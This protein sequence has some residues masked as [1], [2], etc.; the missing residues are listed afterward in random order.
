MNA[1]DLYQHPLG[2]CQRPVQAIIIGLGGERY[3]SNF[4]ARGKGIS[5]W[6]RGNEFVKIRC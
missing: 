2:P 3:L 4:C 6:L 5:K 1:S